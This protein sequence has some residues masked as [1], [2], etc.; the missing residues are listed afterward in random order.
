MF[1]KLVHTINHHDLAGFAAC[2]APAYESQ[3][4]AHPSRRFTGRETVREHWS[5][6]F[7]NV[8]DFRADLIRTSVEDGTEWAEWRWH[9]TTREGRP[10]DVRG[11]TIIG[12]KDD[13]IEWGRLY[14]EPVEAES[15]V[16]AP[17]R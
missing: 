6:F 7:E 10:F 15:R 3:Q 13:R 5:A 9:G 12:V 1:E 17:V 14:M 2:F 16:H 8:P 11:V 4:P